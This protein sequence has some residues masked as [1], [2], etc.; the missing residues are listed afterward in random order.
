[1]N[2]QSSLEKRLAKYGTMSLALAAVSAPQAAKAS[3]II[4]YFAPSP[5]SGNDSGGPLFFNLLQGTIDTSPVIGDYELIL[6]AGPAARLKVFENS[7][8]AS[9]NHRKFAASFGFTNT[10]SQKLSSAARLPFGASIGPAL[11]FSSLNGTLAEE[12]VHASIGSAPFGH[13][14]PASSDLSGY[15]GLEVLQNGT[16]EYG[17]ADIQ[18]N[19]DYSVSL[20]SFALQTD[21]D[22][23]EAGSP[24]PASILLLALGAAGI[25][26]YRSKRKAKAA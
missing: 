22:P 26:A 4:S 6:D 1:L 11:K 24:E 13:F 5:G 20:N 21:G 15:L 19:S 7:S 3:T 16:P 18:V 17:W 23:L 9:S 14:N 2:I 8:L 10:S 25:A 12:P